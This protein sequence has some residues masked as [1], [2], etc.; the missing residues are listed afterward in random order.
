M[1]LLT[2]SRTS[3]IMAEKMTDL[4]H[5]TSL[6]LQCGHDNSNSFSYTLLK[7][8]LNAA[9]NRFS[10]KFNNGGGLLLG[11]LPVFLGVLSS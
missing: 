5:F 6:I 1:L 11:M 7:F 2:S 3:S 10:E 9:D 4:S 8:V